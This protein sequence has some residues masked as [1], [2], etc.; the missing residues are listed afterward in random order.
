MNLQ[1]STFNLQPLVSIVTPSYNQA[2]YLEQTIQSVLQQDYPLL[3][4]IVVDGASTDGSVEIIKKYADRLT[5][6]VSEPDKGQAEAI[7]KGFR[8]ARG[9]I[10]AWLNSDDLYLP[11]AIARAVTA[12]STHPKAGLVYGDAL[13]IDETGRPF[14]LMKQGNWGLEDLLAFRILTQPAV[15][16]RRSVLEQAGYLDWSYHMLLDHQLWIRMARLAKMIYV[17]QLWAAARFHK[18]AKNLAQA[19]RFGEE[20]YL[21][22]DWAQTQPDLAELMTRQARRI[23]ASAHRFNARYLLDGGQ[24]W[25][26]LKSYWRSASLSPSIA[27]IEWHRILFA[28][29]SLLGLG[30]LKNLYM[31]LV[32]RRFRKSQELQQE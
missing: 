16:M 15:F 25:A 8:R 18:G 12:F 1:P 32:I 24:P 9:E 30:R 19:A 13:S 22:L 2:Q 6:W 3:E 5:W 26:A 29:L 20:A 23:W 14:N 7:N 28:F 31:R 4:Y 10:V 17:P 27:L 21:V 11:G